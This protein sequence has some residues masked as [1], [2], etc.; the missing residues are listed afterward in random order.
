MQYP[1]FGLSGF[2]ASLENQTD[3]SPG[4]ETYTAAQSMSVPKI[5][6]T[7]QKLRPL[8]FQERT[9]TAPL[10]IHFDTFNQTLFVAAFWNGKAGNLD[11][12]HPR[13][14]GYGKRRKKNKVLKSVDLR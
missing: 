5:S 2:S 12:H 11:R 10:I 4:N 14:H 3:Q 1:A 13:S 9:F 6:T 7:P 8:H